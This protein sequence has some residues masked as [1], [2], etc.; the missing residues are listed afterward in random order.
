M[1]YLRQNILLSCVQY[2]YLIVLR[3]NRLHLSIPYPYLSGISSVPQSSSF[4]L[5]LIL[6]PYENNCVWSILLCR[7]YPC[8]TDSIQGCQ[9]GVIKIAELHFVLSLLLGLA[10][11][12]RLCVFN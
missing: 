6:L 12:E 10:L 9:S 8:S 5:F 7:Y 2:K 11:T 3:L 1:T 4:V